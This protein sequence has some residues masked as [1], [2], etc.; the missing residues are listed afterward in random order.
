M[1]T[2]RVVAYLINTG[3]LGGGGGVELKARWFKSLDGVDLGGGGGGGVELKARW[4]KSLDGF[5]LGGRVEGK[6]VQEFG[7]C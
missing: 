3:W 1:H 5:D 7:W 6:V 2:H 4:F